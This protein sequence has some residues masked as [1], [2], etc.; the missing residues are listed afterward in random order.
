MV[1]HSTRSCHSPPRS[2]NLSFV[3]RLNS[4]IGVPLAEYFTSE[5]LPTFP[6][7]MTL[8]TLFGIVLLLRIASLR[9][10]RREGAGAVA[11]LECHGIKCVGVLTG[12]SASCR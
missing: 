12:D 4:A 6:T 3:A 9:T 1:C 2:L 8:L 11:A 5:A 10:G 7:R